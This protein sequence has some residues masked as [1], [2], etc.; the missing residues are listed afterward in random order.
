MSAIAV[1]RARAEATRPPAAGLA[2]AARRDRGRSSS[3]PGS[4]SRSSRRIAPH[5]PLAQIFPPAQPPSS[6]HL[7]G[8]DELG[9]DVLSRVIYGPR[10]SVPIALLIVSLAASIGGV[11]GGA[12]RL[13]PR[14]V[15]GV[16]M[17]LVDLVFAFPAIILAMVVA[18]ALGRGPPERGTRDRDRLMAVLRARRPRARALGRRLGVRRI[19]AAARLVGATHASPGR[20]PNVAGPV[21]CSPRSTSRT[22]SCCSPGSRSSGSARSR[23]PPNGAR[24]S[25]R[26]RSTSSGGGSG[27]FPGLA[28]FTAVLAFNF[29]G[30]S[31]ATCSTRRLVGRWRDGASALLE[32]EGL[33]GQAP[34]ADGVRHRRRRRR[35]RGR[36]GRRSFG[37]AG[38]SGSGKTISMLALLGLLPPGSV[39][40]GRAM[41]GG[42]D[43]LRLRQAGAARRLAAARSGWS[44]RI[45]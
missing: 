43:L 14:R 1:S 24:W 11:I 33:R 35:L 12:R 31:L 13:L 7:F 21:S 41:F 45:R 28:I 40:E 10:V 23:R 26:A 30:D 5:D 36:A 3:S 37:V 27:T 44:S 18:A 4:W 19:G 6:A 8:T 9:R 32:V 2:A 20:L 34:D 22:R 42:T 25:P 29:L 39:V 16:S 15:D 17:R 38:E